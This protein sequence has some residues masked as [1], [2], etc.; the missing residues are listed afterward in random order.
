MHSNNT[1]NEIPYGY[2]ECGCGQLTS[3][4]KSSDITRGYIQGQPMRFLPGHY[5]RTCEYEPGLSRHPLWG[6]WNQ[7]HSRCSNPK[8]V[9]FHNYGAR[10]IKVCDRWQDF[11]TFAADMG[12][13]P[14]GYTLDRIDNDG[15]Y[16]PDNCRWATLSQQMRNSR[17]AHYLEH[18]GK[19]MTVI[20]WATLL[21]I[22]HESIRTRLRLGWSVER[23][24]TEPVRHHYHAPRRS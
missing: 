23:A 10:G 5:S 12:E 22:R 19:R 14:N 2:C 15:P 7:M 4:A 6:T 11:R 8:S 3:L 18:D 16:S 21:N 9:E 24:L 13:R 20:E 17:Q 1:T